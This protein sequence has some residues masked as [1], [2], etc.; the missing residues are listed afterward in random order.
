[1][2]KIEVDKIDPQSGTD[3]E[4]GTSGDTITIPAGVTFDSSAATITLPD[5]SV[6]N[7]QL[8]NDSITIDGTAIALGGTVS[9]GTAWQSVVTAATLTTVAGRGYP[10]N[11][12]SNTCTVTLPSSA[13]VGDQIQIVDYAGTFATNN[14]TLTSSLKIEGGTTNKTL[15]TNREGVTITYVDVTQGWVATSGVN[16]GDQALDPLTYSADFLVIAGGGG[17]GRDSAGSSVGSAGGAGGYRNSFSSETSGGGGSS[18][19]ELTFTAGT[20]YTI[21]IG[22]GG[23][24]ATSAET[25]GVNGSNSVISGTGITTITSI[26]GGKGVKNSSGNAGGNGGSG[27]GGGAS[28]NGP[29]GAG[30]A[31]QG[32]NG[33]AGG[34]NGN[35]G[36]GGG[37]AGVIGGTASG[38]TPGNGG[39]GLAS[40]ITGSAVT[41]A[42]G[43]GGGVYNNGASASTGG[44]GGGGAGST[45]GNTATAG[46]TNTGSGG[47][48]G[49]TDPSG[50]G[51]GGNG[52]SGVV[53][54]SMP[55]ASYSGTTTGSPTVATG[56]SGKTVLT[57]NASGSYTA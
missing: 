17:G 47:G 50:S 10:I 33:G 25:D 43:G 53:I 23:N 19:T 32:Y 15:T 42:G 35:A 55:D 36:A 56:V 27:G 52:G 26:G 51:N 28:G 22:A 12:T 37:G 20:A 13:S 31:N 4:L 18:E 46:T 38:T 40:S 30:T 3:L 2:S 5:G 54:L 6:T 1:M 11:T 29:G 14:I 57:F 21:T 45:V 34:T 41:R 9:T 16:S 44:T 48:G 49:G 7:D 8:V 39:N 24:G